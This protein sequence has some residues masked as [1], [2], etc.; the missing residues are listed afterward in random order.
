MTKHDVKICLDKLDGIGDSLKTLSV[1]LSDVGL[2]KLS[3]RISGI[4]VGI[5]TQSWIIR[6]TLYGERDDSP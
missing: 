3:E 5:I 6:Q 4:S 2:N 1:S